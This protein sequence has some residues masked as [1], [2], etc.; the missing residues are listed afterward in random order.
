MPL[1]DLIGSAE[2]ATILHIDR[3]SVN[4][5]AARGVLEAAVRAPGATGP[6][7]FYRADVLALAESRLS[8]VRTM[9]IAHD[10]IL[11]A[12]LIEAAQ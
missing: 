2:A 7:L 8:K 10:E 9:L 3:A 5:W 11:E 1:N 4:R 6:R 12:A